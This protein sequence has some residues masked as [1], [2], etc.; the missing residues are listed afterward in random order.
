MKTILVIGATHLDVIAT[1]DCDERKQ[2]NKVGTVR[3]WPGGAAFNI[4]ANLSAEHYRVRL[5]S[6]LNPNTVGSR[7]I[8]SILKQSKI[9]TR[10][11]FDRPRIGDMEDAS[12]GDPAHVA[13]YQGDKF[14]SGVT[15]SLFDAL[16]LPPDELEKAV[17]RADIVAIDTN[18]T[19]AQIEQIATLCKTCERQLLVCVVSPDKATR[20]TGSNFAVTFDV[21][22]M[23]EEEAK[24]L[25]WQDDSN[26]GQR[27]E[28]LQSINAKCVFITKAEC[29]WIYI[30][31]KGC[32]SYES[33]CAP[34]S[35][36]SELGAGD[37][38]FSALCSAAIDGQEYGNEAT[39][40]RIRRYVKLVLLQHA[41]N[42]LNQ[43]L[44]TVRVNRAEDLARTAYLFLFL[45]LALLSLFWSFAP[46]EFEKPLKSLMLVKVVLTGIFG[47]ALGKVLS[48][49][50]E[51]S[52]IHALDIGIGMVAGLIA[53]VL[54]LM[55]FYG[56]V[57]SINS[58]DLSPIGLT[59]SVFILS[60]AAGFQ[61]LESLKRTV[62][63]YRDNMPQ[64]KP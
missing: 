38:L 12:H 36:Q 26:A 10:Y 34:D 62:D 56:L 32:E 14:I 27:R 59:L 28:F 41:P 25:Q 11:V 47:G 29:G 18:L 8:R 15:C 64:S 50:L 55:P 1:F 57:L 4:A 3:C 43:R 7:T 23:N 17:R 20:L 24:A 51:D 21:V 48:V 58:A 5:F 60:I 33:P 52:T 30:T 31:D 49:T 46:F 22:C 9:D 39:L 13:H 2:K 63:G 42:M 53:V 19:S 16:E 40:T 45:G 37:A 6:F 54:L 44:N 61:N 35:I